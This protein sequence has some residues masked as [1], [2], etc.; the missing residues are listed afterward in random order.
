VAEEASQRQEEGWQTAPGRQG[1]RKFR[2]QGARQ[3]SCWLHPPPPQE[4]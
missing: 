3:G 4:S 1:K 2:Q